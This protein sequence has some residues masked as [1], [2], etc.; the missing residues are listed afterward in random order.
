VLVVHVNFSEL[1]YYDE[2]SPSCLRWKVEV[3]SGEHY[4]I[5]ERYVGDVAGS[6][7]QQSGYWLVKVNSVSYKV[8]RIVY[9]L[10]SGVACRELVIDHENRLRSDNKFSNLKLVPLGSNARNR[11]L[12][13]N[14]SSGKTGVCFTY[15]KLHGNIYATASWHEGGKPRTKKFSVKKLGLIPS[16]SKACAFREAMIESLMLSGMDYSETHGQ[17]KVEI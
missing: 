1:F 13:K 15:N 2:T 10:V 12:M 6:L 16:W 9:E 3:R 4:S 7:N 17:G 14:N 8:H 11:S 5:V